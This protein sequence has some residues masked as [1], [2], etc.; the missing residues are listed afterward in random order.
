MDV[1]GSGWD[2]VG[3]R[4][5]GGALLSQSLTLEADENLQEIC[6]SA[7]SPLKGPFPTLP[8]QPRGMSR[9]PHDQ[10]RRS[11]F[12][13]EVPCRTLEGSPAP[14]QTRKLHP[15]GQGCTRMP[16]APVRRHGHTRATAW[17]TGGKRLSPGHPESFVLACPKQRTH[18]KGP[19]ASGRA[20][21]GGRGAQRDA[22]RDS[23]QTRAVGCQ[24]CDGSGCTRGRPGAGRLAPDASPPTG[25]P[26]LPRPG[27]TDLPGGII[28]RAAC[29]PRSLG[30]R[31]AIVAQ[32][33]PTMS[34]SVRWNPC[35]TERPARTAWCA[36]VPFGAC[37]ASQVGRVGGLAA[38]STR[39]EDQGTRP[40]R[41]GAL[42]QRAT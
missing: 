23:S 13:H 39:S 27:G 6:P 12:E 2:P 28:G 11:L 33:G 19:R 5:E 34:L 30:S 10:R 38:S 40:G 1:D 37:D 25:V 22:G 16:E 41:P 29:T 42:E 26:A 3:P 31:D 32:R 36:G 35:F 21:D 4:M 14:S 8:E 24:G 7:R 9:Q 17:G 18:L 20:T 15:F